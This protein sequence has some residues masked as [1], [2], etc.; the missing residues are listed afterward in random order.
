MYYNYLY[1]YVS[2][3]W[4]KTFLF[5]NFMSYRCLMPKNE[6]DNAVSKRKVTLSSREYSMQSYLSLINGCKTLSHWNISRFNDLVVVLFR[7]PF[8]DQK[9]FIQQMLAS[10]NMQ[11]FLKILKEKDKAMV[12]SIFSILKDFSF[13]LETNQIVESRLTFPQTTNFWLPNWKGLQMKI[14][15]WWNGGKFSKR[16]ENNVG[17]GEIA[18]YM[19]FLFFPQYFQK[20]CTADT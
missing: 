18:S 13:L 20:T 17:K 3:Y 5:F 8:L 11:K 16:V 7:V 1:E 9:S 19:Q 10:T 6:D 12:T 14:S 15:S 4:I 2:I